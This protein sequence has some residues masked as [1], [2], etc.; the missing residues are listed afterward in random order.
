S[1]ISS[2][3]SGWRSRYS[4]RAGRSP[5]RFRSRKSSARSSTGFRSPLEVFIARLPSRRKRDQRRLVALQGAP[6]QFL[7]A[8]SRRIGHRWGPLN[9]Y[10]GTARG[11]PRA[12]GF[13][14]WGRVGSFRRPG[15]PGPEMPATAGIGVA[16]DRAGLAGAAG[17]R[18][19]GVRPEQTGGRREDRGHDTAM[20]LDGLVLHEALRGLAVL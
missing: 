19:V 14:F 13:F 7:V 1:R 10:P 15:H 11:C 18:R 17:D 3:S 6:E 9:R 2:A 16:R 12:R 4:W 5:R 8:I 20:G